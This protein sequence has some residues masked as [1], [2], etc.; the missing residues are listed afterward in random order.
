MRLT[1]WRT[2][3]NQPPGAWQEPAIR[4]FGIHPVLD[5][6]AVEFPD[7]GVGFFFGV[8]ER[9]LLR[10]PGPHRVGGGH[11]F[12]VN[13]HAEEVFGR[14]RQPIL[15]DGFHVGGLDFADGKV[16]LH[17]RFFGAKLR[18][19]AA[20]GHSKL[21]CFAKIDGSKM[22]VFQTRKLPFSA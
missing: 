16:G 8:I 3:T 19:S 5:R 12:E 20:P 21:L 22:H 15:E 14:G 6:P 2:I 17:G 11:F 13:A 18:P 7:D 10:N 4:V 1:S 9:Q